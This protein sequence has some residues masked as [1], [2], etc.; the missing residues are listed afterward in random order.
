[1][2]LRI[3]LS[4]LSLPVAVGVSLDLK[5]VLPIIIGALLF[6]LLVSWEIIKHFYSKRQARKKSDSPECTK[7]VNRLIAL[8]YEDPDSFGLKSHG[9]LQRGD[10]SFWKEEKTSWG[11][12]YKIS[13]NNSKGFDAQYISTRQAELKEAYD[14]WRST[15]TDEALE[16][17]ME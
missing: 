6:V 8:L 11:P 2:K 4:L 3:L 7:V 16:K 9:H 10:L 15:Y 14:D 12:G 13:I 5:T 17:I 1:M